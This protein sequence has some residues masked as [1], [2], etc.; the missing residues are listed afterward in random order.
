[1][2]DFKR[3]ADFRELVYRNLAKTLDGY[4]C[5]LTYDNRED[6]GTRKWIF[7]LVF[8]GLKTIEICND[9]WRDYTEYFRIKINGQEIQILNV[10][11]YKDI[12]TAYDDLESTIIKLVDV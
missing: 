7:K 4:G 6:E 2:E 10:D 3:R 9:D 11:K 8:K 5:V 12:E 1:M